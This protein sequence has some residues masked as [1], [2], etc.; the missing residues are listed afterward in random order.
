MLK[1]P[2]HAVLVLRDG[3]EDADRQAV[4]LRDVGGDDLVH[5]GLRLRGRESNP[6]SVSA[7]AL[8]R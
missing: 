3:R 5:V 1:L 4:G 2:K 7:R 6:T 8:E